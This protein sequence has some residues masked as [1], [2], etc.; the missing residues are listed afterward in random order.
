[1]RARSGDVPRLIEYFLA[2]FARAGKAVRFDPDAMALLQAYRWPGNVRELRNLIERLQI[3]HE[4]GDVRASDL[5]P[6]FTRAPNSPR[7]GPAEPSGLVSLAEMERQHVERVLRAT[8]W[9]KARAARILDVDIKT[10]N[11][12]I[13]DFGLMKSA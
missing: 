13:R 4:G 11:K 5:P 12:K 10:L 8:A 6:E 9:N 3:L 1:L 7:S 2:P